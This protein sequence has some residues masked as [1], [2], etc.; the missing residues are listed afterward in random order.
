MPRPD[1]HPKAFSGHAVGHGT[2]DLEG[3]KLVMTWEFGD[4]EITGYILDP[5]GD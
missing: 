4:T 2:D 5:H 1:G 3:L